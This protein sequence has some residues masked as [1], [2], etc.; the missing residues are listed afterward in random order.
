MKPRTQILKR[1]SY[2]ISQ[3]SRINGFFLVT[4]RAFMGSHCPRSFLARPSIRF[5]WQEQSTKPENLL[6]TN[7]NSGDSGNPCESLQDYSGVTH[8]NP[9]SGEFASNQERVSCI[10]IYGNFTR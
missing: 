7:S 9:E 5:Q 8:K 1:Q 2:L 6:Q 4:P 10:N 3:Y